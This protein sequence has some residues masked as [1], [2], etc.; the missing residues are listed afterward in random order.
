MDDALSIAWENKSPWSDNAGRFKR[1]YLITQNVRGSMTDP[2][3][4]GAYPVSIGSYNITV[5]YDLD[6]TA[7]KAERIADDVAL[8]FDM[9]TKLDV[10]DIYELTVMQPPRVAPGF[11]D[12][13]DWRIVVSVPYRVEA[14]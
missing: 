6:Q 1:P 11:R 7:T 9:A 10:G 14:K 13:S 4:T 3:L 5:V 2:T 12:E 8:R